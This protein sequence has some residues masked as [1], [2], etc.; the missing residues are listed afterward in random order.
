MFRFAVGMVQSTA[1]MST[2]QR[3]PQNKPFAPYDWF[4]RLAAA[5]LSSF[6][7]CVV[8]VAASKAYEDDGRV[9]CPWATR[10]V[11][12]IM[13]CDRKTVR[14]AKEKLASSGIGVVVRSAGSSPKKT[15]VWDLT[16][17]F[18]KEE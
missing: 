6:E 3:R 15:D 5:G 9:L 1:L 13:K 8:M 14:T 18:K 4:E 2:P 7:A 11:A 12:D 16:A 17:L 10:T